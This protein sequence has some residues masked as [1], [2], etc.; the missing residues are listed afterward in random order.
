M[1]NT[2]NNKHT[3]KQHTSACT[4]WLMLFIATLIVVIRAVLQLF[5]GCVFYSVALLKSILKQVLDLLK[6]TKREKIGIISW[7]H[8][9]QGIKTKVCLHV[10]SS[11]LQIAISLNRSPG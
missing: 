11:V 9:L 4:T 3:N 10:Q 7:W 5:I 2:I 8:Y 1:L 6:S